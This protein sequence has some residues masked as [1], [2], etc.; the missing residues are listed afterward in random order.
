MRTVRTV[1]RIMRADGQEVYRGKRSAVLRKLATLSSRSNL[2]GLTVQMGTH[3]P[4]DEA[5]PPQWHF[6]KSAREFL[7][8]R[9]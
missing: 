9:N 3:R 2:E 8:L 4:A 1:Y 6:I 7:A 5:E